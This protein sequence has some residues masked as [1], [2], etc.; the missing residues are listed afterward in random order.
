MIATSTTSE[1]EC[2]CSIYTHCRHDQSTTARTYTCE[3]TSSYQWEETSTNNTVAFIYVAANTAED[4]Q[5]AWECLCDQS[6]EWAA[7]EEARDEVEPVHC[8]TPPRRD[9]DAS[10]VGCRAKFTGP[11]Q[12]ER[13][14]GKRRLTDAVG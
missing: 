11:T 12:H 14:N 3:N 1:K 8:A 13:R 10:L 6:A 7:K 2:G 5:H 4:L 9:R